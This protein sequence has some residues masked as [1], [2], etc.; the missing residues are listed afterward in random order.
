M[1]NK[2]LRREAL[3]NY[4]DTALVSWILGVSLALFSASI[5]ATGLISN[6]LLFPLIVLLLFPCFFASIVSHL[7]SKSN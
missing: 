2:E 6:Y 3:K 5:V 4:K 1:D 7:E